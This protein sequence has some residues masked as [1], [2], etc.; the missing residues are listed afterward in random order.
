MTSPASPWGL[1]HERLLRKWAE[2]A[3]TMAV[4]HT[5]SSLYYDTWD[6]RLGV[7]LVILGA[8]VSSSIF[9][10]GSHGSEALTLVNGGMSLVVVALTGIGR[11]LGL[12]ELRVKHTAASNE[13]TFI[14]MNVDSVLSFPRMERS[15]GPE[16]TLDTTR[17]K[18][19]D[20]KVHSPPVAT[21]LLNDY[22][23]NLT[24]S[25]LTRIRSQV[26]ESQGGTPVRD[27]RSGSLPG[28]FHTAAESSPDAPLDSPPT[29]RH[30]RGRSGVQ[31]EVVVEMGSPPSPESSHEGSPPQLAL[32]PTIDP[33]HSPEA[34]FGPDTVAL[35]KAMCTD[36]D[37]DVF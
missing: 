26:N 20:I 31:E 9:L 8:A 12:S 27:V 29:T 10:S 33:T 37:E 5:S 28:L 11:F 25:P 17:Q 34:A 22:L 13:Y 35:G 36:S 2:T 32:E 14:A 4:L 24:K 3:K 21:W 19:M 23:G 15:A 16:E 1:H 18:M 7:P 6:K 30:R